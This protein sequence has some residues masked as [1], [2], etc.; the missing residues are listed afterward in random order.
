MNRSGSAGGSGRPVS[1]VGVGDAVLCCPDGVL[2]GCIV[3]GQ[4]GFPRVYVA[5]GFGSDAGAGLVGGGVYA[6]GESVGRFAPVAG[7][8]IGVEPH[9]GVVADAPVGVVAGVLVDGVGS[10]DEVVRGR[11][12]FAGAEHDPVRGACGQRDVGAAAGV[13]LVGPVPG[14][15]AQSGIA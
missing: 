3:A 6:D 8:D 10:A 9:L 13:E 4:R 2:P 11:E 15:Q 14:G 12:P 7:F 5:H 1:F